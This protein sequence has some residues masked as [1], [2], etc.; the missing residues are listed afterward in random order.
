M[1]KLEGE[2]V[3]KVSNDGVMVDIGFTVG[4]V[5]GI[6]AQPFVC[7]GDLCGD[8]GASAS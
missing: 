3:R 4:F 2:S 7:G 8:A 6:R 5:C 1:R